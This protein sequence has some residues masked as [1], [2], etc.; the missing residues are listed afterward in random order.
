[1]F[2]KIN[3][4]ARHGIYRGPSHLPWRFGTGLPC[5]WSM[6][7]FGNDIPIA[8]VA[9]DK[10]L[11]VRDENLREY[12]ID[13]R[14][15][16]RAANPRERLHRLLGVAF[17]MQAGVDRPDVWLG[18]DIH[19]GFASLLAWDKKQQATEYEASLPRIGEWVLRGRVWVN[20]I[21]GRMVPVIAGGALP[22]TD[23]FT[24]G[25]D[26]A[27]TT[28]SAN[29]SI[30]TG[31]FQVLAAS[32]DFRAN[33]TN[34]ESGAFHNVETFGNN[35]YAQVVL[36]A[37]SDTGT[38]GAA[39]RC[40][41]AGV[42]S[43]YHFYTG[44]TA[45]Y[46]AKM[47]TGTWTQL[48]SDG[49]GA[50]NGDTIRIESNGTTQT[51]KI[52][53]SATGTPGAQTDSSLASGKAGISGWGAASTLRGDNFEGGNLG[54]TANS[55]SV[56]G[57]VS[58]IAGGMTKRDNKPLSGAVATITGT[59]TKQTNRAL[60]GT[61]ATITGGVTSIRSIL[62]SLSGA[63]TTISGGLLKRSNKSLSGDVATI[64][65]TGT[66]QTNR[67]LSGT[68]ATINGVL[69]KMFFVVLDGIVSV[70]Q[71]VLIALPISAAT[72]FPGAKL[73]GKPTKMLKGM[74]ENQVDGVKT[75]NLR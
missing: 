48:G 11:P 8:I 65:G 16:E 57:T 72:Y 6:K 7:D 17:A 53:G 59:G 28:Y 36:T 38:L 61:V 10:P 69:A 2:I 58:T 29:W 68:V 45:N 32:D 63:I 62:R 14:W 60:S 3:P 4:V 21:S 31:N 39:T 74:Q 12:G 50:A 41:A 73:K 47:V 24:T 20:E 37:I 9:T 56:S 43:Y 25:A 13:T 52:N 64:T 46:L 54:G 15:V 19:F 26:A 35:Q 55:K 71:G 49:S 27:L 30:N 67:A 18:R 34:N 22:V 42:A 33:S 40:G 44:D 51:P 75:R 66:K 70:I 5:R 1:M 23:A